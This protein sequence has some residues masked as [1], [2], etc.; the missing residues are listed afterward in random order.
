MM[1][2]EVREVDTEIAH[3]PVRYT[4]SEIVQHN[5]SIDDSSVLNRTSLDNRFKSRCYAVLGHHHTQSEH[6][7]FASNN[8]AKP[9]HNMNHGRLKKVTTAKYNDGD[10]KQRWGE[11]LE[12]SSKA[13]DIRISFALASLPSDMCESVARILKL[14]NPPCNR[15][16]DF[17]DGEEFV[18]GEESES[19]MPLDDLQ[20]VTLSSDLCVNYPTSRHTES[21]TFESNPYLKFLNKPEH[22]AAT[23][24]PKD[25]FMMPPGS[26]IT[27]ANPLLTDPKKTL[28]YKA[29]AVT[30]AII[31]NFCQWV[32]N[33]G[34]EEK[35]RM[36]EDAVQQMFEIGFDAPAAR[37]LCIEI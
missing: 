37:S 36:T 15:P 20:S 10:L 17:E 24:R 28:S 13:S 2:V 5:L 9:Q 18:V 34:G 33:L 7:C 29:K 12:K 23:W 8:F 4:P 11:T 3:I 26:S 31:K 21:Q 30:N 19:D 25:E 14:D 22:L 32:E 16:P 1:A 27:A 35:S 6:D